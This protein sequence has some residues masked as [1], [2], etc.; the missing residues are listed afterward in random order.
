METSVLFCGCVTLWSLQLKPHTSLHV[1]NCPCRAPAVSCD[2][3]LFSPP[4]ELPYGWEKIEDPQF[5]TY[6]VE[7]VN[8]FLFLGTPRGLQLWIRVA[9]DEM[10]HSVLSFSPFYKKLLLCGFTAAAPAW[11]HLI[12][13]SSL[14][15]SVAQSCIK[16]LDEV[17]W[18]TW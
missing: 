3:C 18:T 11:F 2:V 1:S 12:G 8:S 6:Y 17:F 13:P 4:P 16:V 9:L 15:V 7:W 14:L 10:V 5:G